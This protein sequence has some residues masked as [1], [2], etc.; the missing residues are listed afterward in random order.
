MANAC[1]RLSLLVAAM[2]AVFAVPAWLLDGV[3]GLRGLSVAAFLCLVPGCAVLLFAES[4][5]VKTQPMLPLLASGARM[6]VVML[7]T[8]LLYKTVPGFG[9]REFMVWLIVIY[10]AT[11]AFET[12]Y[13]V[14][15]VS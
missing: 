11:L 13:I 6:G 10:M 12:K 1:V 15:R 5:F 4:A 8:L 2:W 7:F 3:I 14:D 9:L